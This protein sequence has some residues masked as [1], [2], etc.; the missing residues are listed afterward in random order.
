MMRD[1]QNVKFI[2]VSEI[3]GTAIVRLKHVKKI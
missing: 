1:P 3:R 2:D